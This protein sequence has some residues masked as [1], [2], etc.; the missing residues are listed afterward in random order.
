MF[1][2]PFFYKANLVTVP[3]CHVYLSDDVGIMAVIP[4]YGGC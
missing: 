1:N 2:V 4:H 3:E